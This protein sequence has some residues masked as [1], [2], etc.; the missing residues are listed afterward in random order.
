MHA[1]DKSVFR[2]KQNYL[3]Y[4]IRVG[5]KERQPLQRDVQWCHVQSVAYFEIQGNSDSPQQNMDCLCGLIYM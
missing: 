1:I 4:Y 2:G 5:E 3:A